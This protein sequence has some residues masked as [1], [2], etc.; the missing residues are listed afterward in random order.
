MLKIG[1]K[2][3]VGKPQHQPRPGQEKKMRAK[4]V[5]DRRELPGTNKLKNEIVFIPGGDGGIGKSIAILFA[6]EGT[7]IA[8]A[9]LNE[10]GD[11]KGIKK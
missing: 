4:P 2:R 5:F 11:V 1:T 8:I 7:A 6:K 9:Y 3:R 10:H